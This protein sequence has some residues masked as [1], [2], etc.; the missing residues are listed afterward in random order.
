MLLLGESVLSLILEPVYTEVLYILSFLVGMSTVQ[1]LQLVHFS[2]EEFDP[3]QHALSRKLRAGRV[4]I[5]LMSIYGVS[6]IAFG[7]GLK[8][9]L[10][11][12][13]CSG[14]GDYGRRGLEGSYG[15]KDAS[16]SAGYG[17]GGG[18]EDEG[19]D[20]WYCGAVDITYVKLL[21][22]SL[23]VAFAAQQV[24]HK[25]EAPIWFNSIAHCRAF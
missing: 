20:N 24:R 23:L 18:E 7:V 9:L 1:M 4:W 16:Y 5:V 21:C 12:V 15:D 11:S 2:T 10:G 22:G 14:G 17:D 19:E 6:L 25:R 8:L 13:V 3:K